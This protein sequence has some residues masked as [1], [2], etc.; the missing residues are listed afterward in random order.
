MPRLEALRLEL[1]SPAET[2]P[3]E[4]DDFKAASEGYSYSGRI[5]PNHLGTKKILHLCIKGGPLGA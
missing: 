2:S 3:T 1:C 4:G 5:V